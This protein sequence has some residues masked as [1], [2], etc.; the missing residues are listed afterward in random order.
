MCREVNNIIRKVVSLD[1]EWQFVLDPDDKLD[2]STVLS[3]NIGTA[4]SVPGSWEEQGFGEPS[5]HDPIAT[6]KKLREYDGQAWYFR[7]FIVPEEYND[8]VLS[9]FICGAHWK[10]KVWI[11]GELVGRRDSLVTPHVYDITNYVSIGK[12]QSI[13]ILVDNRMFL[14]LEESHIHSYHTATNWGGITGGVYIEA[15]SEAYIEQIKITPNV[16][17]KSVSMEILI[18]NLSKLNGDISLLI[19][20]RSQEGESIKQ[21][22][23]NQI[24][25]KDESS[26]KTEV[27]LGGNVKLWTDKDPYLYQ[28]T[29]KLNLGSKIIDQQTKRFGMRTISTHNQ[30]ILLNGTPVFLRGYVDCCV[31]PKTGY[32]VWDKEHYLRQFQIAKEFGF[33]HVRLHG[34]T[35]PKPFWEAADEMGMLVQTELPHWSRFYIQRNCE[36]SEGVHQFLIRELERI[37]NELNEHPSFIMLSMG[38][39]LISEE[40]HDALNEMVRKARTIDNSRLYTDNTGFGHLPARDREGDYYIPSLNW[41]PP[42]QI[43]FAATPDTNSDYNKV[44]ILEQ[45]PLIAHEHGQFTM[46]VRPSEEEKYTG[47]IQPNWLNTTKETLKA[48]KLAHRV[49]EFINATGTHLVRS[50]KEALERARRT[51]GLSGIQ[52]LDVRDFPGQ[53]HAT[54]GILDVFW[55]EKGIISS[56]DFLK[57][58][59]ECVLLMRCSERTYFAGDIINVDIDLSNYSSDSLTNAQLRWKLVD[60]ENVFDSGTIEKKEIENGCIS[61]IGRISAKT[62]EGQARHLML[63]VELSTKQEIYEN[64]WDFWVYPRPI[65][66]SEYRKVWTDLP[67]LRTM[68]FNAVFKKHIGTNWLSYRKENNVDL[69]I[70]DQLSKDILQFVLD[71]GNVWLMTTN[72][73][74]HD[75]V[76]TRYLPIFW[77]YLWF[78]EQVGTTMGMIIHDHPSL[79]GF[80]HDGISNWQWYHLVDQTYAISLDIVPQISPIVEVIDNFNRAKRLAYAFETKVGKGNLFVSTFRFLDAGSLKRPE[81]GFLME[82]IISYLL[83]D[84]FKPSSRISVGELLSMFK[85]KGH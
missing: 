21:E 26:I 17:N 46:Y 33:N 69:A 45:K 31:F 52:L 28:A 63:Q 74:Q 30:N 20:I 4:I 6:W 24:E 3:K 2:I 56:Q 79:N 9:L 44:T 57:F 29:F 7:K 1:G 76:L 82:K 77:N 27:F 15:K 84:N 65:Q 5:E 37:L 66:R 12:E 23:F 53:G 81:V 64:Q 68:L 39:E 85:L 60:N 49:D 36:P 67:I 35:P 83:S 55:E 71:G 72:G 14:P 13:V 10:T 58:N 42:Y 11:N 38:N 48:K 41:H 40:G 47:I 73:K 51:K 50:L 80:P 34:W 32:P 59:G 54:T 18:K 61:R 16:E 62:P 8:R 70:T 22:R 25:Q 78:P 75:D 19:D 43:D